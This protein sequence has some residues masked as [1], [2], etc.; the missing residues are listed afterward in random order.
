MMSSS[1]VVR[2]TGVHAN[3]GP[4]S[5]FA[6]FSFVHL[7]LCFFKAQDDNVAMQRKSSFFFNLILYICISVSLHLSCFSTVQAPLASEQGNISMDGS[8]DREL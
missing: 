5:G 3:M 7:H 1:S 8:L 6:F 4:F 2:T